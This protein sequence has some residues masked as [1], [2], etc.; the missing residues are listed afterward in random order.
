MANSTTRQQPSCVPSF[1]DGLLEPLPLAAPAPRGILNI[2]VMPIMRRTR[3]GWRGRATSGRQAL[4]ARLYLMLVALR[5]PPETAAITHENTARTANALG[6]GPRPPN[7]L[8]APDHGDGECASRRCE[9]LSMD[10]PLR[11]RRCA[12][13]CQSTNARALSAAPP[14]AARARGPRT[15]PRRRRQTR[16][17][18]ARQPLGLL[19]KACHLITIFERASSVIFSIQDDPADRPRSDGLPCGSCPELLRRRR[20]LALDQRVGPSA[21]VPVLAADSAPSSSTR[22]ICGSLVPT[23][24]SELSTHH[25]APSAARW[26]PRRLLDRPCVGLEGDHHAGSLSACV[27]PVNTPAPP[28]V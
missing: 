8:K 22:R 25:L 24:H 1:L 3:A 5:I 28:V 11:F 20:H 15:A 9:T 21:R 23:S 7:T 26:S 6:A 19:A 17:W 4:R 16:S 13:C 10:H 14:L 27:I 12:S 2:M 18:N